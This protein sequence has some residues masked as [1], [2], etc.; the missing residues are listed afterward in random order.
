M[1]E[2]TDAGAP[3]YND[4]PEQVVIEAFTDSLSGLGTATVTGVAGTD[5]AVTFT[6]RHTG[7]AED[8]VPLAWID[9]DLDGTYETSGNVAPTEPFGLG[10]ETNFAV[11]P[12]AE[13]AAGAIVG[14]VCETTKASDVFEGGPCIAS[15][16]TASYFYDSGDI[17]TVGG[18]AATP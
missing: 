6:I 7:A 13:A 3:I 5:G 14:P 10:G 17:F 12:A 11:G 4:L 16:G 15:G 8:V 18:A 2:V 9:L 1:I